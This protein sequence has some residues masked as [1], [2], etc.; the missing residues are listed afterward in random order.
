MYHI[1]TTRRNSCYKRLCHRYAFQ[2]C[3][4]LGRL[5]K[6]TLS[7][8]ITLRTARIPRPALTDTVITGLDI[9]VS[10]IGTVLA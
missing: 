9:T 1:E 10:S 6:K 4:I 3:L 8:H 2:T 7:D 5:T